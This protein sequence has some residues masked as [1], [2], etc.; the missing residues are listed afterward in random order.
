MPHAETLADLVTQLLDEVPI[1]VEY[2]TYRVVTRNNTPRRHA[3]QRVANRRDPGLLRQLGAVAGHTTTGRRILDTRDED[4]WRTGHRVQRTTTRAGWAIP[5]ASTPSGSPGWD[6]DGAMSP[7][8]TGR[9]FESQAP[10]RDALL[11]EDQ[12][13]Q[14]VASLHARLARATRTHTIRRTVGGRLRELVHLAAIADEQGLDDD[15]YQALAAVRGWVSACRVLLG[16]D[17]RAIELANWHCADCGG[18]VRTRADDESI[19]WCAGLGVVEGPALEYEEM[20][21]VYGSCG[22]KW[23]KGEWVDFMQRQWQR[24]RNAG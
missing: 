2:T 23:G 11:L 6:A 12:I 21:V 18:R 4:G 15:A 20:P 17:A 9:S 13:A 3:E 7:Q 24:G 10:A 16:Y 1:R 8:P 14:E 5:G 19:V 22:A